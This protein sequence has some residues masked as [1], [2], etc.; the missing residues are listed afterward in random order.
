MYEC[1]KPNWLSCRM[2]VAWKFP[3]VTS[4]PPIQAL[5]AAVAIMF[6]NI[7]TVVMSRNLR[8]IGK[9]CSPVR[10]TLTLIRPPW[11]LV[12]PN[13]LSTV[14]SLRGKQR[15]HS[16]LSEGCREPQGLVSSR[17][18]ENRKN[19]LGLV[20]MPLGGTVLSQPSRIYHLPKTQEHGKQEV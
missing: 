6:V 9:Q 12:W 10:K 20:S 19:I 1:M 17:M 14:H 8:P 7:K 5:K 4:P 15:W 11:L 2:K 18:S 13:T 16:N 3:Q